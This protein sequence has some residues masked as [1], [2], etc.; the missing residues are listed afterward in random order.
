MVE[1]GLKFTLAYLLGSVLGSLVV[2]RFYGGVD[3][4]KVGSG[5]PGGTNALRTQG[6]VF[7]LWVV[8]IDVGKGVV[9]V[10]VLPKL[11]LPGVPLDPAIDREL[12][13]Y[14]AAFAVVLGHVFPVWYDF[15]GGKGGA[16]AAGVLGALSLALAIPAVVVW[17]LIIGLTGYVG[18]ATMSAA[19]G[20]A[21]YVGF[22]RLS[23]DPGFFVA[24][25]AIAALIIYAHRINIERMRAGTEVRMG[26]FGRRK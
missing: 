26:M 5:N 2:G 16:T 13:G 4:R 6:K 22:T 24:T 20:V 9:A 14:A 12:L 21:A 23:A 8:L 1:L 19:A 15:K 11:A 17:V 7:A 25:A 10:L 3:I 18:L